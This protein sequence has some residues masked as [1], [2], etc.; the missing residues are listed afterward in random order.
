MAIRI[1]R[2]FGYPSRLAVRD[3]IRA[4]HRLRK[5]DGV[6]WPGDRGP[7]DELE[8]GQVILTPP[9]DMVQTWISDGLAEEVE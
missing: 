7:I 9:D 2:N 4:F 8:A 5:N 6:S 1:L 3:K